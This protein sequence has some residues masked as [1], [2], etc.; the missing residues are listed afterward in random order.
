MKTKTL[1][2]RSNKR[3]EM[4]DITS[5]VISALKEMNAIDGIG[6]VYVPHTTAGVIINEG[7]DPD[8]CADILKRLA[9]IAPRDAGYRHSE[10]NSDAHIK[11]AIVGH[12]AVFI[13]KSASPALGTWQRIFFCEFDGPRSRNFTVAVVE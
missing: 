1:S 5:M 3:E 13:V 4:I 2:I 8:V 10:G 9:L 6:L 11:S 7:A 12:S